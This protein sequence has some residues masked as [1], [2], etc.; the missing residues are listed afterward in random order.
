MIKNF[1]KRY[2]V[3]DSDYLS[4]TFDKQTG[5]IANEKCTEVE[6]KTIV[7]KPEKENTNLWT[8]NDGGK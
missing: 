6:E 4:L 1:H 5:K 8:T 3:F 2:S 7:K